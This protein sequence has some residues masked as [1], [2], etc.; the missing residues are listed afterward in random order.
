MFDKESFKK[1]ISAGS[2]NPIYYFKRRRSSYEL[3]SLHW[4][5]KVRPGV[6]K[7]KKVPELI[8]HFLRVD[9]IIPKN[10]FLEIQY[11]YPT[12]FV[13][14]VSVLNSSQTVVQFGTPFTRNIGLTENDALVV[15]EIIDLSDRTD[16]SSR[17]ASSGFFESLEFFYRNKPA[18]YFQPHV[19]GQY[20]QAGIGDRRE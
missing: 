11:F 1:Y 6:P 20:H 15:F 7:R 12:E 2:N 13:R 14:F 19:F 9:S 18:F 17:T 16:D 5:R 8:R 10:L 3:P 4:G